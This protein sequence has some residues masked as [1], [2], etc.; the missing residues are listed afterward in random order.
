MVKQPKRQRGRPPAGD[1]AMTQIAIRVTDEQIARI[2]RIIKARK[3][4]PG[5]NVIIRELIERGLEAIE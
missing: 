1:K 5:R 4:A 3:G 2:D